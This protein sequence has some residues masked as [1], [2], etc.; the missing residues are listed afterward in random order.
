MVPF[1]EKG[2]AGEEHIWGEKSKALD[3]LNLRCALDI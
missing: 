3:L 1:T 2:K